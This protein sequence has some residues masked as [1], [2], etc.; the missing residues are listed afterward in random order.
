MNGLHLYFI[1]IE[2]K[3]WSDIMKAQDIMGKK[4]EFIQ[5]VGER[6]RRLAYKYF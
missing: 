1:E 6:E 3:Q 4:N 2:P 5:Y